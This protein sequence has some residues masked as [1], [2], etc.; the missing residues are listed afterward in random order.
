MG[1]N[2]ATAGGVIESSNNGA[3]PAG[4]AVR[5]AF[6]DNGD[7][8]TGRDTQIGYLGLTEPTCALES[9][10]EEPVIEGNFV[11]SDGEP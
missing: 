4:S 9:M 8:G 10:P 2:K 11:V 7:P 1:G 6:T 5:L 3:Y